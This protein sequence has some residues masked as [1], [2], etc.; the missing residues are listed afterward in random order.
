MH[1]GQPGFGLGVPRVTGM[2][3]KALP[4]FVF[5]R[6]VRCSQL[7]AND[8]S[9][10]PVCEYACAIRSVCEHLFYVHPCGVS[11]CVLQLSVQAIPSLV[12]I[13]F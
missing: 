10:C 12:R 7:E 13:R 11:G 2:P 4:F 8:S 6:C 3:C 5:P 1:P 9:V